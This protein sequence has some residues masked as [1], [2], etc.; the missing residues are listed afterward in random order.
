MLRAQEYEQAHGIVSPAATSMGASAT[1]T[2]SGAAVG[3][4]ATADAVLPQLPPELAETPP[5]PEDEEYYP[6]PAQEAAPM[7]VAEDACP[8]ESQVCSYMRRT[9]G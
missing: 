7:P 3:T 8:P 5:L 1:V 2:S 9:L 4:I 6:P